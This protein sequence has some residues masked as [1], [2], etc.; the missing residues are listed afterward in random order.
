[1]TVENTPPGRGGAVP[2]PSR[3]TSTKRRCGR[4]R[5]KP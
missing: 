4:I 5:A 1:M 3:S 2:E